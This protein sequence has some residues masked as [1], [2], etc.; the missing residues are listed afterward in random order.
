MKFNNGHWQRRKGMEC[1]SPAEQYE[2]NYEEDGA[3]LKIS[4]P[5]NRI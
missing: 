1:L 4:A 5:V 2:V 3:V